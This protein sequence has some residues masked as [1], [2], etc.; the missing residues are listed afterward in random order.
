MGTSGASEQEQAIESRPVTLMWPSGLVLP[1]RVV[2]ERDV[3]RDLA[4]IAP[5][6]SST[7][8]A[9]AEICQPVGEDGASVAAVAQ[10]P[11]GAA[12]LRLGVEGVS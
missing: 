6:A 3:N 10:V 4:V 8:R 1:A 9:R 7:E 5:R 12:L 2:S 11:K